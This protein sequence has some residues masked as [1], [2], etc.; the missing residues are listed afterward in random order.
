VDVHFKTRLIT[1]SYCFN[2]RNNITRSSEET[3]FCCN[4]MVLCIFFT[5]CNNKGVIL[6]YEI[7]DLVNKVAYYNTCISEAE[8]S[9]V[10]IVS[11]YLG[12]MHTTVFYVIYVI[13]MA[14]MK[15][16]SG[17]IIQKNSKILTIAQ[18]ISNNFKKNLAWSLSL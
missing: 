7:P 12:T 16:K 15:Y 1:T 3:D 5:S 14:N 2:S 11:G 18:I 8:I 17:A 4:W 6:S 9:P 10:P 13:Y